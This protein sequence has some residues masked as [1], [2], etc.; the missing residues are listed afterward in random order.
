MAT[1]GKRL[2]YNIDKLLE[3]NISEISEILQHESMHIANKHHIRMKQLKSKYQSKAEKY[4][5]NYAKMFNVA[6][7]LAINSL[8][9]K[10]H[11]YE[12]EASKFLKEG[13]IPGKDPYKKYLTNKST[14]YYLDEIIR[15][16]KKADKEDNLDDKKKELG[17]KNADCSI[18]EGED[19]IEDMERTSNETISKA[20][21]LSR[22]SNKKESEVA[23]YIMD[24]FNAPPKV[25]WRSEVNAFLQVTT[26]GR[27]N[28]RRPNRR[29]SSDEFIFPSRK[30]KETNNVIFLVD[31]SG[32]MT[33]EAVTSVYDHISDL[34]NA[35]EN[36]KVTLVP[37]DDVVF[38]D[39]KKEYN[40][41][42]IP[43]LNQ[44]RERHSYGGTMYCPAMEY[45]ESL[46]PDGIVMLTDL[47]PYDDREFLNYTSSVPF[48]ILSVYNHVFGSRWGEPSPS[49]GDNKK[50]VEVEC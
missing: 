16:L 21:V 20:S 27:L 18:I 11:K 30:N 25:N 50:V 32:S 6:A 4:N 17:L 48:L 26:K 35:S 24:E 12:W 10:A 46:R 38:E 43:I 33:D 28:Y 1:D 5:V 45:A 7:D 41:S 40:K 22:G 44:D 2:L 23:S 39:Y 8:L 31:V 13:C 37:F 36:L 15:D 42:N 3:I 47:M 9:L 49:M 29:Y 19:S 14:E 34:I